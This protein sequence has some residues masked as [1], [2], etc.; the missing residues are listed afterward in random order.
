[1]DRHKQLVAALNAM[2]DIE[3][4]RRELTKKL[5]EEL[6]DV[7][8]QMT[9]LRRELNSGEIEINPQGRLI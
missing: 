6:A 2:V 3:K 5:R 8:S 9:L 1:M 7:K 4:R